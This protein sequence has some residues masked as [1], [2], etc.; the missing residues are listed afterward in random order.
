M[1]KKNGLKLPLELL[2]VII[3][4]FFLSFFSR[5]HCQTVDFSISLLLKFK[6]NKDLCQDLSK[7]KDLFILP[8]GKNFCVFKCVIQNLKAKADSIILT[9]GRSV[10]I[11]NH[12]ISLGLSQYYHNGDSAMIEYN[13]YLKELV[14]EFN[15]DLKFYRYT[16]T[17]LKGQNSTY[18][19]PSK[20]LNDFIL[21]DLINIY[22]FY[23][24]AGIKL[25]LIKKDNLFIIY[26]QMD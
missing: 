3:I 14:Q 6:I 5:A 10:D 15:T 2:K 26:T 22:S 17:K 9:E 23:I 18:H 24:D 11:Y 19:V 25:Y 16:L 21:F 13:Q 4:L 8:P 12:K 1:F 7:H 20:Y